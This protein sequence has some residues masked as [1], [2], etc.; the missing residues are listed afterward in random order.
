MRSKAY[1]YQ[2][3]VLLIWTFLVVLFFKYIPSKEIASIVAGMGF[4][5]WPTLFLIYEWNQR[6]KNKIYIFFL[7]LFLVTNALP[8]F[9]LRILNWGEDFTSLSL[10]GIPAPYFHKV[11][12]FLY[13]VMLLV[14]LISYFKAKRL[15]KDRRS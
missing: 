2:F 5:A 6:P 13:L 14:A 9:L 8:I 15:E 3:Q 1:F 12:N 7:G 4:V 11:S 10:L